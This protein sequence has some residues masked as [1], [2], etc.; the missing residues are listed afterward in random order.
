MDNA[1]GDVYDRKYRTREFRELDTDPLWKVETEHYECNREKGHQGDHQMM[2]CDGHGG[3]A[4]WEPK[5]WYH[6]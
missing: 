2:D 4:Y 6:R 5:R 3:V 1:C